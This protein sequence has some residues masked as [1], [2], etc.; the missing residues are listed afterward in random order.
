MTRAEENLYLSYAKRRK[1]YNTY[2]NA[3]PSLFIDEI[4]SEFV[5]IKASKLSKEQP[6]RTRKQSRRKKMLS[7]FS[8]DSDSQENE[9]TFN[10]GSF[11]YHE[12]FG[13]GKVTKLEGSGDKAKIS[14]LFEGNVSKKLI[15]QYANLTQLEVND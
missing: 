4:P 15:A 8:E 6:V 14:V 2:I 9:T 3:I 10:V 5:E 7:Y 13:K 11:V 12:T 1:K